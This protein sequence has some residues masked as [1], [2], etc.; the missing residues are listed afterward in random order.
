MRADVVVVGA[1]VIG[2]TSAVCLAEAGRRVLV[3]SADPPGKTTSAVAGAMCRPVIPDADERVTGW[4]RVGDARFRA[5]AAVPGTGVRV[6]RGRLVSDSGDEPPPWAAAVPGFTPCTPRERAGFRAGFW[7]ELPV[8]D[9][10]RYL[11][12]LAAR[13]AAAGG[14]L[15]LRPVAA[16]AEAAAEAPIVV[17]C[18]GV[19]SREL[20]GDPLVHPIKGQHVIVGNPGLDDFLFEEGTETAWTGYFPHHDRVVLGGVALRDHGDLTPDPAVTAAILARCRAAEPRLADMPVLGVEV[21]LRPGRPRVRV[22]EEALGAARCIHHYGHGRVGVTLS[23]GSAAD[24]LRIVTGARRDG[25][26]DDSDRHSDG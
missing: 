21:G 17:N 19:A 7:V 9:M 10:R 22:E 2:L 8:A 20:A 24:V 5:L 6:M 4:A 14:R 15:E 3:R 18:T 1:G 11:G 16:L 12:Y 25:E 23:W 13:L 26:H